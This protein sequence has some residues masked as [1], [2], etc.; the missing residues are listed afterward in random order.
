MNLTWLRFSSKMYPIE[1]IGLTLNTKQAAWKNVVEYI[2][3]KPCLRVPCTWNICRSLDSFRI[4]G[5]LL[6]K[7]KFNG[8]NLLWDEVFFYIKH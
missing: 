2:V 3:K 7:L 8:L 6:K 1:K 4:T 5:L